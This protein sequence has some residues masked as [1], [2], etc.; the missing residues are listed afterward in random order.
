ML[1]FLKLTVGIAIVFGI[2]LA[3]PVFAYVLGAG[4]ALVVLFYF[5]EEFNE[6]EKDVQAQTEERTGNGERKS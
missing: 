1:D 3:I 5:M 2:I 6:A 4:L